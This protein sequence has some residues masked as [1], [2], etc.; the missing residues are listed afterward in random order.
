MTKERKMEQQRRYSRRD[1]LRGAS[2]AAGLLT[3]A[4]CVPVTTTP[5]APDAQTQ[6]SADQPESAAPEA[7]Q[8]TLTFIVDTINDGHVSVRDKW[9]KEFMEAN[10]N[11]TIDHQPIPQEYTTKIQTL[12]AAGTPTRHL[13]LSAGSHPHCDGG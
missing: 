12:Y 11:V 5:A 2:A 1:F 6:S 7:E 3:L 10:P 9:A 8:V 13:P 4:G